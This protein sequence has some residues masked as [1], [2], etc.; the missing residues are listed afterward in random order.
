[1]KNVNKYDVLSACPLFAELPDVSRRELA[2]YFVPLEGASG[3]TLFLAGEPGSSLFVIAR[4]SCVASV[5]DRRGKSHDVRTMS[6]PQSFGELSLFVRGPRL[7]T[8]VA[9]EDVCVLELQAASFDLLQEHNPS[10]ALELV[11][12]VAQRAGDVIAESR[13]ALTDLL[14]R[15]MAR[16]ESF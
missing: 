11:A 10:L 6:A 16:I 4:G 3:D 7:V 13:E 1:M 15:N 5:D 8:V 12:T 9:R 14:L 2:E